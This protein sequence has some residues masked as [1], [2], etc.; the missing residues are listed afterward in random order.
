MEGVAESMM[1]QTMSHL[2]RYHFDLWKTAVGNHIESVRNIR[3]LVHPEKGC[4]VFSWTTNSDDKDS[5]VL[6]TFFGHDRDDAI[7]TN[8]I[9]SEEKPFLRH[10]LTN[11]CNRHIGRNVW[12]ML[13][14]MK[15]Q[16][17]KEN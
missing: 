12:D 2:Y 8:S 17:I 3:C 10:A 16:A 7:S 9:L 11:H 14:S 5:P 4:I 1:C 15:W 13:I 6:I